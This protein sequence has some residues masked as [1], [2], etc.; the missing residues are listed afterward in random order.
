[1][2]QT[3]IPRLVLAV[4]LI[5]AAL[6][7]AGAQEPMSLEDFPEV[8][9]DSIA[10][11]HRTWFNETVY[12]IITPQ[13]RE[14]FVR[15]SSDEQRDTF[16]EEFWRQRDPT[17]GTPTNENRDEHYR[18]FEY[19]NKFYG[20]GTST[21]GWRTDRGQA[22]ILLGPPLQV[23]RVA[24]DMLVYPTEIWFMAGETELGLPP[25]FYLLF[26]QRYGIGD[27][28]LYSPTSDGPSRLL[29][30][31]GQRE[32]DDRM[33]RQANRNQLDPGFAPTGYASD[34]S[35]GATYYTLRE[36]DSDLANAAISLFPSEAGLE[37]GIT[38]LQ[39]DMLL[40]D[41]QMV[42]ERLMPDT[43]WAMNVLLGVAESV[44]RFE[45]LD[46]RAY[47]TPLL[48]IDGQPFLH[49]V[50]Q[51]SG[52]DLHLSNYQDQYYFA[53]DATGSV[54]AGESKVLQSF[55]QNITGELDADAARRFRDSSFLYLDMLPTIPGEQTLEIVIENKVTRRFGRRS[56][57]VQ[58]PHE[59]PDSVTLL[60]PVLALASREEEQWDPFGERLPFQYRGRTVVPS[61]DGEFFAG[62]E[63]GVLAQVLLPR[64]FTGDLA[65]RLRLQSEAGDTV[66]DTTQPID[67]AIADEHGVITPTLQVPTAGLALGG[68]TL[69]LS[70]PA[71]G[72]EA[73]APLR[74]VEAPADFVRP[75]IN[76]Q[77]S[78]PP[79]DV[80]VYVERARQYREDGE[81]ENA[82]EL[83]R[84]AAARDPENVE[85]ILAMV[86]TLEAAAKYQD[87][88]QLLT[89]EVA[90]NPRN[91][92][93]MQRLA[94]AHAR[95][96]QHY[97]AVRYYE[98]LR[99]ALGS[100]TTEVLNALA[101]EYDADGNIAKAREILGRSLEIDPDQ[102]EIRR[103]L[104]NL[105][106]GEAPR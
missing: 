106:Q 71:Q 33:E 77:P 31:S 100:D 53:F 15:L 65:L 48:D 96:N 80:A 22:H 8:D 26:Y 64:D 1:M 58:V 7:P 43:R 27:Y 3:A 55:D 62:S 72:V 60:G 50:T 78:P 17:P 6:P 99:I 74:V 86:E 5:A 97:D 36:I 25:F 73:G 66:V 61:V 37:F 95:L 85:I 35:I 52:G 49:F 69:T 57:R 20:R 46:I 4:V 90:R 105:G 29:N 56:L 82:L 38:P 68:Y 70:L 9:L 16:V 89:P 34:P 45:A 14:V 41:I 2:I 84:D 63:I 103:L 102:P 88:V 87:L 18:R 24:N 10:E 79:T 44:V 75:F 39:S 40:A 13:E 94:R 32:V 92:D 28:R 101:V 93:A 47:V 51:A 42:P 91:T 12:W 98:R 19:A 104:D 23:T 67:A 83:L 59:H 54:T 81:V 30:A 21:P 76:S 11:R